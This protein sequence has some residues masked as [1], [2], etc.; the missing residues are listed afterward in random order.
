MTFGSCSSRCLASTD[1]IPVPFGHRG[2]RWGPRGDR[3][4][5]QAKLVGF[6]L[7]LVV[8]QDPAPF[9]TSASVPLTLTFRHAGTVTID[10]PVTAP[11]TP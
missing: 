7:L 2:D 1:V 3:V 4:I 11:G 5:R 10:A 6:A 9:E 8:L